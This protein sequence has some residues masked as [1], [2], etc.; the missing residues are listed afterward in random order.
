MWAES[1]EGSDKNQLVACRYTV[2][3]GFQLM[4]LKVF[5]STLLVSWVKD[6]RKCEAPG[7]YFATC[8]VD[9]V[10]NVVTLKVVVTDLQE[11]DTRNFD[12]RAVYVVGE[13]VV[14]KD[15]NVTVTYTGKCLAIERSTHLSASLG[16]EK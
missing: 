16:E 2:D 3:T 9:D 5:N 8:V 11:G 15:A 4:Q 10:E 12:C 7:S 1:F 6:Y 14:Y 13:G